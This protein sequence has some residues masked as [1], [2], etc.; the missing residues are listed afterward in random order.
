[1]PMRWLWRWPGPM[2][3]PDAHGATALHVLAGGGNE[4]VAP[5]LALL[6]AGA[7]ADLADKSGHTPC[8]PPPR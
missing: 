3:T 8:W 5:M 7:R 1:M 6:R 4:R 2:P